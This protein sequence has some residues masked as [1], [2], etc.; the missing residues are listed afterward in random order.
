MFKDT[1]REIFFNVCKVVVGGIHQH[2]D[3][4]GFSVAVVFFIRAGN[5]PVGCF[6]IHVFHANVLKTNVVAPVTGAG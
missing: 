1:S 2:T 3:K 6:K 5:I 4:I